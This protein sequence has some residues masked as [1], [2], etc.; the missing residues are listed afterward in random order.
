M[1]VDL[2]CNRLDVSCNIYIWTLDI[3]L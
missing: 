2:I 3:V 1:K